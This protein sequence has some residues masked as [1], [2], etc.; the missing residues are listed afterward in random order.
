MQARN[1]AARPETALGHFVTC[2]AMLWIAG[3]G[4]RLTILA[5]PPLIR[6]IHDELSLNETQVGILSGLPP[7]L[8]MLS[9]V[10]GSLLIARL[11]ARAT[12]IAGLAVASVFAPNGRF[13]LFSHVALT[14]GYL[15]LI[16]AIIWIVLAKPHIDSNAFA[17]GLFKPGAL[18]QL[19]SDIKT[20]TP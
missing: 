2:V 20:P 6:A 18:R 4:L 1:A 13:G 8:F 3:V 11:G 7:V 12:L 19:F 14:T 15:V 10:P 16:C 5:V 9:A 17:P